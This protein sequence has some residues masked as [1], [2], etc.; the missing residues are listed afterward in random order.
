MTSKEK[1]IE[2]HDKYYQVF[3][4]LGIDDL[5]ND[6]AKEH[7]KICAKENLQMIE[8]LNKYND[9]PKIVQFWTDVIAE[10]NLL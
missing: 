1:A 6:Y 5:P 7:S 2:L 9:F 3:N 4:K 10:I 8:Y